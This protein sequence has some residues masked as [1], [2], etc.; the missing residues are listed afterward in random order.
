MGFGF[1]F[2]CS[3]GLRK[4]RRRSRAAGQLQVDE[5]QRKHGQQ[6]VRQKRVVLLDDGQLI[7][8]RVLR[9]ALVLRHNSLCVC[10]FCVI[11][12]HGKEKEMREKAEL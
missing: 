9:V 6:L 10:G 1:W 4:V 11:Q 3:K 2:G 5:L 8:N 7:G 12:R